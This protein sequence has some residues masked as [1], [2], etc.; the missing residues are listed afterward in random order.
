MN[1][2]FAMSFVCISRSGTEARATLGAI[3]AAAV[4][5]EAAL[6]IDSIEATA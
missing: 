6:A 2:R 4:D 1:L 5:A 3:G